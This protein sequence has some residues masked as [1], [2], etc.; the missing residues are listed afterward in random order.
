MLLMSFSGVYLSDSV[1]HL[2]LHSR[3]SFQLFVVVIGNQKCYNLHDS[4]KKFP[5]FAPSNTH[6]MKKILFLMSLL[7]LMCAC[8]KE[9]EMETRQYTASDVIYPTNDKLDS[10]IVEIDMEI[11]TKLPVDSVLAPIQE[12]I[13]EQIY[14][15][16]FATM[17]PEKA[18][19]EYI[20]MNQEEY[21]ASNKE[22]LVMLGEEPIEQMPS[23]EDEMDIRPTFSEEIYI[24]ARIM[25]QVGNILAYS[26]EQ[27]VYMGG[28]HGINTRYFYNY[29]LN[30]GSLIEEETL[31]ADGY[32]TQLTALL[33]RNL[34]EQSEALHS[35]ADLIQSDYQQDNIVPNNNFCI[36]SD[37]MSWH[38]N[39]YDI[40]PY[41]YGETDIFVSSADLQPLLKEDINLWNK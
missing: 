24:S 38:F 25:E 41:A 1:F 15:K 30:N 2:F 3:H 31:F 7:V 11:P 16:H 23:D 8:H 10:M 34:V 40:A 13:L 36:Q 27:Y 28:A 37:G 21:Q 35:E 4:R 5:T 29:D 17:D 6:V 18:M 39:P 22:N 32:Q 14:G 26:V 33:R 12:N 9:A 20:R 19:W